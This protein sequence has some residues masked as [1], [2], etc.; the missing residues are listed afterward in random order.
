MAMTPPMPYEQEVES[1][2]SMAASDGACYIL[3][4]SSDSD[5]FSN[6][7]LDSITCHPYY[8]SHIFSLSFHITFLLHLF[9]PVS[10][11]KP[12]TGL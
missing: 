4:H 9:T 2:A 5:L 11:Q 6:L 10:D 12:N 3:F 8:A 7:I 1:T